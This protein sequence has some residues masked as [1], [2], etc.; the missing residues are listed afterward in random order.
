MDESS[1]QEFVDY[2]ELHTV[3]SDYSVF[4][5]IPLFFALCYLVVSVFGIRKG[6]G[7]DD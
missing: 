1:I 5:I 4:G 6:G 7:V 2:I 3:A